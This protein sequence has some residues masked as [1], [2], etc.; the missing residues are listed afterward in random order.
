MKETTLNPHMLT[1]QFLLEERDEG[2]CMS[3]D[4][5]MEKARECA[6]QQNIEGFKA[7]S[8][9]WLRR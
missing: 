6:A 3:N 9:G 2:R 7:L 8:A 5:L 4:M 1:M